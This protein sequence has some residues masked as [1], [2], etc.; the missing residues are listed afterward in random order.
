MI[1][2]GLQAKFILWVFIVK[3]EDNFMKISLKVLYERKLHI[4]D[5][6][7]CFILTSHIFLFIRKLHIYISTQYLSHTSLI[8]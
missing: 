4:S 2:F 3:T 7:T 5:F 1:V 6:I 8:L